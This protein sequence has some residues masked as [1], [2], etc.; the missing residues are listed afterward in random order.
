V[1]LY[2][3]GDLKTSSL[4][5]LPSRRIPL[6]MPRILYG[7]MGDARGHV[8][9]ARTVAQGMPQHE[10]LFVGGGRVHD[11]KSQGYQVADVPMVGTLYRNNRVN[12]PATV[13]NAV[14]VL[15]SRDPVVQRISSVIEEYD[16]DLILTD[17]E[18]F[19]PLAARKLGRPC[20]S[21]DHQHILTQCIYHPPAK[22]HLSRLMTCWSVRNIFSN[23]SLFLIVSFFQL[24][25]ND[26]QTSVVLPPLIRKEVLEHSPREEDHVLV[27]QTSP[28]FL[29]LLPV[30]EQ[31]EGRFI[32]YGF[33]ELPPRRN[34]I[35]KAPSNNGFL[36]DLASARYVITNGGHN[37]TSEALFLGKPV[38]SFPI[39]NA[40]EQFFN[41]HFLADFGFGD[42]SCN[43]MPSHRDLVAFESRL[44]Q[45]RKKIAS[46]DFLGNKIV[47][48]LLERIMA[49]N[50]NISDI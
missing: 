3:F 7:V 37:V 30:L 49:G 34:V 33:G 44:D 28:T 39:T 36:E 35:F 50:L 47:F 22:Q 4:Q 6:L 1:C 32:V 25:V 15:V 26:P 9:R 48:S 31:V 13:T 40:Y 11:L 23:A 24:P 27:Y 17:Y 29:E 12:L 8:N 41:A 42:Y 43:S 2:T 19:T 14:K 45:C 18:F 5:A 16:P 38:F 21:L 46:R 20:I 10:F